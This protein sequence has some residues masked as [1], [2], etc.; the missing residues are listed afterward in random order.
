M[1]SVMICCPQTGEDV[2]TGIET[3][4][5]TWRRFPSVLSTVLCPSCGDVHPWF[6]D[7]AWLADSP[8][9]INPVNK[10]PLLKA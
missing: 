9:R 2:P 5:V 7:R 10:A 1:A 3:D 8:G 6:R 4:S